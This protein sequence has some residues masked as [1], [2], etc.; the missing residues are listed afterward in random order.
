M[1][2]KVTKYYAIM[3]VKI[4]ERIGVWGYPVIINLLLPYALQLVGGVVGSFL[5]RGFFFQRHN[6][7]VGLVTFFCG[8][9]VAVG[10]YAVLYVVAKLLCTGIAKFGIILCAGNQQTGSD[11]YQS[12]LFHKAV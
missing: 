8:L 3:Y 12:G 7:L 9:Y 11:E 4:G 6:I 1:C 10:R 2:L 5:S